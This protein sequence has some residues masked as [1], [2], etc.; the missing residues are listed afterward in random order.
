VRLWIAHMVLVGVFGEGVSD[1]TG[2][3]ITIKGGVAIE[4]RLGSRA[5][6]TRDL[7]VTVHSKDRDLGA[8]VEAALARGYADFR[9]RRSGEP[10]V[11]PNGAI[12]MRVA[13]EYK[14][15]SW[16]TV[17]VDVTR[18]ELD[19]MGVEYVNAIRLDEFGLEAPD[20][21]PCLPL[22]YQVAQKIHACTEPSELSD[23]RVRDLVD[24]LLLQEF[25][26]NDSEVRAACEKLFASRGTHS[27][28]PEVQ[29]ATAWLKEYERLAVEVGLSTSDL[30]EAVEAV[31]AYI[32]RLRESA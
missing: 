17:Q 21:V 9:F 32:A 28:P 18:C 30:D 14:G 4:L 7:D 27:W 8:A 25:T 29:A 16:S 31:R 6:A 20:M 11:M 12:R 22:A 24:L 2:P 19:D 26:T 15:R 10:Y 5:R 23:D 13:V 1:D 3:S